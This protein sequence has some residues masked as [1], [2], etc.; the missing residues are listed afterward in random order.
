MNNSF[1]EEE[2]QK[3]CASIVREVLDRKYINLFIGNFILKEEDKEKI[4]NISCVISFSNEWED[5]IIEGK[6]RGVVDALIGAIIAQFGEVFFSLQQLEFDDFAMRVKFKNSFTRRADAPVEIKLALKNKRGQRI[7]FF[8][9]SRSMVVAAISVIRKA[10]EYLI[11]AERAILQ[12]RE[13]IFEATKR[14]RFD[15]VTR[16][17][18]QMSCLVK[19]LSY[20][21]VIKKN[22]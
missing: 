6:G 5:V 22:E 1:P 13:S 7:Y 21:E 18:D 8:A 9:E 15:L 19:I 12:L 16:Y 11:N 20:E 4:S 2:L 14:N 10:F 17:T 3:K